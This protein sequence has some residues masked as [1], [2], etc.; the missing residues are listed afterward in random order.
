[1]R[2]KDFVL[3]LTAVFLIAAVLCQ[4]VVRL[5]DAPVSSVTEQLPLILIDAG[6]GGPDGGAVSVYGVSEDDINLSISLMLHDLLELCGCRVE[7]TRTQDVAVTGAADGGRSWKASDM[8]NRLNMYNAADLT[9]SIHQ[10]QFSQEKYSGAQL[11]YSSN[12]VE[13]SVIATCIQHQIVDLLQ[14]DNRREIKAAGENIFLLHRAQTP[15]VIVEC[16]FLSNREEAALLQTEAYQQ[17]M[18]FAICCG[19]L[20][21]IQKTGEEVG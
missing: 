19:V 17:K 5:S 6:H 14:K 1:M 20:E 21:Y 3:P 9:V 15:A 16:G 12:R 10:N 11:F 18:A 2:V 8:R 13:S 4:M 7:M